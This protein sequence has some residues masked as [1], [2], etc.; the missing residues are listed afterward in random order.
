MLPEEV[1]AAD[2]DALQALVEKSLVRFTDDRYWML[3]TIRE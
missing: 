2:L 3:E 1:A